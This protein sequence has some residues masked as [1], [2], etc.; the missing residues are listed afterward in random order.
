MHLSVGSWTPSWCYV[1]H[2]ANCLYC[3]MWFML[4]APVYVFY[5]SF[6][7]FHLFI[8]VFKWIVYFKF[9]FLKFVDCAVRISLIGF[10]IVWLCF[11]FSSRCT[12]DVLTSCKTSRRHS[13][14]MTSPS[15]SDPPSIDDVDLSSSKHY[16]TIKW[17][18]F[19]SSISFIMFCCLLL[20]IW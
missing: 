1:C 7:H 5:L 19:L 10:C 13:F 18:F 9:S 20:D 6:Y 15:S 11:C 12:G 16:G 8:K 17:N 3:E 14:A 2:I 4:N